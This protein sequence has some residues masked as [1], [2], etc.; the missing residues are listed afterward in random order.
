MDGSQQASDEGGGR[1]D[2]DERE[3]HE[4]QQSAGLMQKRRSRSGRAMH[5]PNAKKKP[6]KGSDRLT[7]RET[8]H[9]ASPVQLSHVPSIFF[10]TPRPEL[11]MP[12]AKKKRRV[13]TRIQERGTNRN[14]EHQGRYNVVSDHAPYV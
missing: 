13:K 12:V 3:T 11:W 9:Q 7:F 4:E 14:W 10:F 2:E 6:R 8:F 5:H 1:H